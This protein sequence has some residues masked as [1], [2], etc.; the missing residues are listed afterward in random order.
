MASLLVDADK[1]D[2]EEVMHHSARNMITMYLDWRSQNRADLS[3]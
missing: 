1:I 3:T 2:K